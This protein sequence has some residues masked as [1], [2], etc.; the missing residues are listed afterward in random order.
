MAVEITFDETAYPEG[1]MVFKDTETTHCTF[2][3]QGGH[4]KVFENDNDREKRSKLRAMLNFRHI[5]AITGNSMPSMR[6]RQE[7]LFEGN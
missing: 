2:H 3:V 5:V 6:E 7:Q 1:K 4:V